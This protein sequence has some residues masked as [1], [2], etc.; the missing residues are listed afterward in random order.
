GKGVGG[1]CDGGA[2]HAERRWIDLV[3]WPDARVVDRRFLVVNEAAVVDHEGPRTRRERR[4]RSQPDELVRTRP[5]GFEWNHRAPARRGGVRDDEVDAV[6]PDERDLTVERS[7][8]LDVPVERVRVERE[9]RTE[10]S[11]L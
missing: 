9:A 6:Q 2:K 5:R 8:D 10:A 4:S 7:I 1:G 3:W 11:G